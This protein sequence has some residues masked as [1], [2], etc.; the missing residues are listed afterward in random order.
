MKLRI[1]TAAL[2][3]LR[4]G[5]RFYELQEQGAGDYFLNSLFSD[6]D[7]L[8]QSGGIHRKVFGFHRLLATRFPHA[9]YYDVREGE[10]IVFRVLDC[11]RDPEH[12]Q[13]EL[14]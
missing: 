6:I 14:R 8:H 1:L 3:D 12:I 2:N 7:T 10:V 5:R 13:R 11:R 9:I 4:A